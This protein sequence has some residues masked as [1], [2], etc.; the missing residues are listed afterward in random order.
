MILRGILLDKKYK[1]VSTAVTFGKFNSEPVERLKEIGCEVMLNPF[2]RPFST[3]EFKELASDADAIIC[4][5]DKINE[6]VIRSLKNCKV[7]AKHGV[8]IDGID[9]DTAKELGI[10]VTNA[11]GT[12]KAEVA[13]LAMG[14]LL[15]M[16]RDIPKMSAETKDGKWIKYPGYSMEGKTIGIIGVGNIGTEMVK[17]CLGFGLKV[18]AYDP[19]QREEIKKMGVKY[20]ELSEMLQDSNYISLHCP[21]NAMS[22]QMLGKSEIKTMKSGIII[23]NTARSQI[24]DYDALY[25]AMVEKDILGYASDVFDF[26]PPAMHPLYALENVYLTPHVGG[27]TYDS[28]YR[29]GSTAVNNVIEVFKGKTPPN[30]IA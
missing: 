24:L 26:E 15:A 28:N 5:N 10:T 18:I 13:D 20:V 17:R 3:A 16:A 14:F 9:I 27:T 22:Y 25:E 7:I 19:V 11:P 8:G 23:V 2:G 29:M 30:L 1:V 4:G 21:L 6:E 12:N